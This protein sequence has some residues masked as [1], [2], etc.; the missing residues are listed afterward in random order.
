VTRKP[1]YRAAIIVAAAYLAIIVLLFVKQRDLLYPLNAGIADAAAAKIPG[2]QQIKIKTADNETLIAWLIPPHTK[3]PV[4]LYFSGNA[5]NLGHPERVYAF[6]KLT[7]DGTG[8]LAV[9][10]RGYGGSS[11][12]PTE[13]GLRLDALSLYGEGVKRYG[14]QRLFAYGHSLGSGVAAR[15]AYEKQV[16]GLILEAPFTSAAA[17][18]QTRYWYVPV[19]YLMRDQFRTDE[20][21][22]RISVPVLILHGDAD[23]VVPYQHAQ[24][25]HELARMPKRLVILKNGT[26]DNLQHVGAT[27]E[28]W[29]FISTFSSSRARA[30]KPR[31][32]D[33]GSRN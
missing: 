11:G 29:E 9:S 17:I 12:Q 20:I 13:E 21:I 6:K 25:L 4:L 31:G 23:A 15:L 2:L 27:E 33:T 3:K 1:F 16:Q 5:G 32:S 8:L 22:G 10:Y 30:A 26:H 14:A 18:A 24:K 7:N 19:K 28:I